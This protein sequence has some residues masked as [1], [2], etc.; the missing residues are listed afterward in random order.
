MVHRIALPR[1]PD[2]GQEAP[3]IVAGGNPGAPAFARHHRQ[4]LAR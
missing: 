1:A 4:Q 3:V 2:G